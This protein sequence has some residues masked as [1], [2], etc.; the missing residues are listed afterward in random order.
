MRGFAGSTQAL[1]PHVLHEQQPGGSSLLYRIFNFLYK[2][3]AEESD[4]KGPG[5][6]RNKHNW[7]Q[8]LFFCS[9]LLW[10]T[11]NAIGIAKIWYLARNLDRD[12]SN[13]LKKLIEHQQAPRTPHTI[14]IVGIDF[15]FFIN[16]P[17]LSRSKHPLGIIVKFT[18][19]HLVTKEKWTNKFV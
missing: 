4:G 13:V 18:V 7:H 15:S 2:D 3:L 17:R 1:H 12:T 6:I 5:R 19:C 14:T 16:L 11:R 10:S 8:F 9:F